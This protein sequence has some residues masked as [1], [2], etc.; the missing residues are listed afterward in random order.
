MPA[1]ANIKSVK[2][3]AT[4][5]NITGY[6]D[7]QTAYIFYETQDGGCEY[8]VPINFNLDGADV[9]REGDVIPIYF[10]PANPRDIRV[11]KTLSPAFIA[12]CTIFFAIGAGMIISRVAGKIRRNKLLLTGTKIT[13]DIACIEYGRTEINA[14][15]SQLI[16]C[17]W[18]N[19]AD[20]VLY[21]F[22]SDETMINLNSIIDGEH[23]NKIDVYIDKT[24]L[25]RYYVDLRRFE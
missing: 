22:E 19:P 16:V 13:A 20:N 17:T 5:T 7:N 15:Q 21:T 10:N 2:T 4:V 3:D 12:V 8:D 1:I 25:K 14:K 18:N 6:G 11:Q 9:I 23:I 24:N